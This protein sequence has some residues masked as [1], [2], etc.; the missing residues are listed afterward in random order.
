MSSRLM[1]QVTW[2]EATTF[3]VMYVLYCVAM[4]F[5]STFESWAMRLPVMWLGIAINSLRSTP[6]ELVVESDD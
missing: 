2:M 4:G 1:M 3:L 6:F 5:N